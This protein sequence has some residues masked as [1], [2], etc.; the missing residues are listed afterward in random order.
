MMKA[1]K[2]VGWTLLSLV[3][4][5]I[6]VACIAM[7]VIFTPERLTPIARQAADKFI[8]YLSNRQSISAMQ[9]VMLTLFL[10]TSA[11]DNRINVSDVAGYLGCRN[12]KVLQ[13]QEEIDG[14]VEKGLLLRHQRSMDNSV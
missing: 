7:Y 5:V 12:L 8:T 1:L 4:V 10:E 6:A 13:Y 11:L 3:L 9:A 2:I 14:L